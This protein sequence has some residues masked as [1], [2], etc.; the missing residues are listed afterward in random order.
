MLLAWYLWVTA[1]TVTDR[2]NLQCPIINL[3]QNKCSKK[4]WLCCWQKQ[5]LFHHMKPI[6]VIF[7]I[8]LGWAC[9]NLIWSY[10]FLWFLAALWS[11]CLARKCPTKPVSTLCAHKTTSFGTNSFLLY[12]SY[13]TAYNQNKILFV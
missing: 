4:Y 2:A 9:P 13:D 11:G 6:L 7:G 5:A 12:I 8:I 1:M 10:C 3:Q